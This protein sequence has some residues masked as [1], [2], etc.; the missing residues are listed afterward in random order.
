MNSPS[1]KSKEDNG[2][3]TLIK[4]RLTM[5]TAH[6]ASTMGG[7]RNISLRRAHQR[8]DPRSSIPNVLVCGATVST[9]GIATS[10][11]SQQITIVM[12]S[13]LARHMRPLSTSAAMCG[14]VA[15]EATNGQRDGACPNREKKSIS[16]RNPDGPSPTCLKSGIVNASSLSIPRDHDDLPHSWRSPRR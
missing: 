14:P 1:R 15:I 10:G 2:I 8:L 3:E 4:T 9:H 6:L 12:I 5:S 16:Q 11:S 13:Y 7:G